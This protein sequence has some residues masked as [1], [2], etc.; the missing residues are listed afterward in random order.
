MRPLQMNARQLRAQRRRQRQKQKKQQLN[1]N[2]DATETQK[3][4]QPDTFLLNKRVTFDQLA[5]DSSGVALI[6]L[7][8]TVIKLHVVPSSEDL[9]TIRID[10]LP[11]STRCSESLLA[12][13][14]DLIEAPASS[15]LNFRLL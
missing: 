13:Q 1:F 15:L 7:T 6:P 14:G 2:S 5:F 10:A 3:D 9:L 12:T 11:P 8:G 4:T